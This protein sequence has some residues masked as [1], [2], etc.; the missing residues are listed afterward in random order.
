MRWLD[1]TTD[2]RD[3]SLSKLQKMV[4][5]GMLQS[6]WSQ[7][8]RGVR[9]QSLLQCHFSYASGLSLYGSTLISIHDYWKNHGFDYMDICQ[10]SDVSVLYSV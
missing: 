8:V 2:L 1:G 7:R 9:S 5:P 6:M 4:K 10:Q 3:M